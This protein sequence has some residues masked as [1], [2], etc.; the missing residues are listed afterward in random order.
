MRGTPT[1]GDGIPSAHATRDRCAGR[2]GFDSRTQ[3]DY[4]DTALIARKVDVDLEFGIPVTAGRAIEVAIEPLVNRTVAV[5][6]DAI[7]PLDLGLSQ[8][9]RAHHSGHQNYDD[10]S[11]EYRS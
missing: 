10:G 1:R 3:L 7:A 5:V 6:V 4:Q 2:I 9:E 8:T 11:A